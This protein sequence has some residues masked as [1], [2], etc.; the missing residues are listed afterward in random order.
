MASSSGDPDSL[1]VLRFHDFR[2]ERL[3][4]W[5]TLLGG[6][7]HANTMG[8]FGKFPSLMRLRV[9]HDLLETLASFWDPTHCCFSIGEMDLV[10]TLEEYAELL[11][12]G[13]LFSETP[14]IPIQGPWSNR[15][16]EKYLGLT[17]AVVRPEISRVDG[18]WR[19]AS[20][21]LDLLTKYFSWNDFP[22][23]LAGDFILGMREWKKFRVN[24]FKIAFAGI[25][26]FPTSAGRIDLG[27]I[28]LIFS[29]GRSIILAILC[30]TIRS[31]SYCRRRGCSVRSFSSYGSAVTCGIS[32]SSRLLITSRDTR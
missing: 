23:E 32:T 16:L 18:T 11:Q 26:L 29:K 30:E 19:K 6:D 28:P 31:L 12:L 10:P 24:A 25:F 15:V 17:S 5:W 2:A 22:A 13:S 1:V 9:D 21:S 14:V 27:V 8:D 7:D 3:R 20:I 4:H